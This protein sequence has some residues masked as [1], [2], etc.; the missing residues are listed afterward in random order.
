MFAYNTLE[1]KKYYPDQFV[2]F[3]SIG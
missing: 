1:L 2:L 3:L